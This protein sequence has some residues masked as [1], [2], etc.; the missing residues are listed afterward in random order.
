[1]EGWWWLTHGSRVVRDHCKRSLR[2]ESREQES[3]KG[4]WR[5]GLLQDSR[6]S[7]SR[8]EW[9]P[10]SNAILNNQER[11]WNQWICNPFLQGTWTR[12]EALE[13]EWMWSWERDFIFQRWTKLAHVCTVKGKS[14]QRKEGSDYWNNLSPHMTLVNLHLLSCI[15]M[16]ASSQILTDYSGSKPHKGAGILSV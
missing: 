3:V 11:K 7:V 8:R 16:E 6:E 2:R 12:I 4:S 15:V 1:M 9:T 10:V 5:K 14:Q 13:R